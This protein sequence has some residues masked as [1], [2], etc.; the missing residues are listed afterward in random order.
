MNKIDF[1]IVI[2]A[3]MCN[4]NGDPLMTNR[5]R[6]DLEGYGEMSSVCLKRKVRDRLQDMG[7]EVFVQSNLHDNDDNARKLFDGKTAD[8]MY[9][10]FRAEEVELKMA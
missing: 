3:E 1:A 6:I 2:T 5:P 7:C 4:P 9:E 8:E 10:I